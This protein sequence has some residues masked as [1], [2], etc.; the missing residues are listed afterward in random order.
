MGAPN[1]PHVA[2][3]RALDGSVTSAVDDRVPPAA[4]HASNGWSVTR[5]APE[6]HDQLRTSMSSAAS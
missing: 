1:P 4:I 5:A 3:Q 2:L 6:L